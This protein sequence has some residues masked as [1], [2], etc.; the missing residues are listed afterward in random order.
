MSDITVRKYEFH[1]MTFHSVYV[2]N[3]QSVYL[4]PMSTKSTQLNLL[5][6]CSS[7][8]HFRGMSC[9]TVPKQCH[10][11][12]TRVW[13]TLKQ[14]LWLLQQRYTLH[15]S[16]IIVVLLTLCGLS[17]YFTPGC[18]SLYCLCCA[19]Q[20]TQVWSLP[21]PATGQWSVWSSRGGVLLTALRGIP[22]VW[23]LSSYWSPM[24]WW[25]RSS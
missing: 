7:T 5:S 17:A 8:L 15:F 16:Q 2:I 20:M 14:S 9:V 21:T 3:T 18:V 19:V 23:C 11:Y 1:S 25:A 6:M 22:P 10:T 12:S 4:H 13:Y 24:S